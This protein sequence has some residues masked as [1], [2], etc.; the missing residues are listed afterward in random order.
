MKIYN[1]IPGGEVAQLIF[2]TTYSPR[3]K[4]LELIKETFER[5]LCIDHV[6][7]DGVC[8]IFDCGNK[9]VT[10]LSAF[11]GPRIHFAQDANNI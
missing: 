2:P 1:L 3:A 10:G 9:A 5:Q 4:E 7:Y 6:V 11:V 8:E